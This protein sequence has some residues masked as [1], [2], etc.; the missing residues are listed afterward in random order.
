MLRTAAE[1]IAHGRRRRRRRKR[2]AAMRRCGAYNRALRVRCAH[3]ASGDQR[4]DRAVMANTR[5]RL[6]LAARCAALLALVR[7]RRLRPRHQQPAP[8]AAPS[9]PTR[10]FTAFTR[11]LAAATSTRPA[12]YSNDETPYTYQIYEPPYGYHYLKR[13]YELVPQAAAR[14]GASRATSTRTASALPADAPADADRRERLRHP[15]PARASCSQP[16]PA[17]AQGRPA[18]ATA[19]TRMTRERASA[20]SARRCDFEHH[21]HAR[22]DRRRL[23]L[24]AQAPRHARASSRRS[25]C[26]FCRVR[27]RPEGVRRAHRQGRGREAAR[28]AWPRRAAT[29]PSS[30]SASGRWPARRRSTSTPAAHPHQGQVPAVE[31]LAGDDLL[32]AGAVGGRRV[33]RAAGHGRERA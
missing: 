33:L 15:H 10:C 22:A 21:G 28:R 30:T 11:A 16:H 18:A 13:P 6:V 5:L 8:G 23:R 19:T 7:A 24:R 29:S 31:V 3:D 17:F 26:V 25:F 12:S 4:E 1:C 14:G 20:T 27:R 9:R 32:R 2:R